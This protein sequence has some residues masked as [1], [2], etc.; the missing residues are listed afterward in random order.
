[1]TELDWKELFFGL[2]GFAG[3]AV[4]GV[5]QWI[6]VRSLRRF[7]LVEKNVGLLMAERAELF[8]RAELDRRN[9]ERRSDADFYGMEQRKGERR[10]DGWCK[11]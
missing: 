9:A 7:E 8:R 6:M 10:A 1:M 5:A 4:F 2:L 3:A 11:L